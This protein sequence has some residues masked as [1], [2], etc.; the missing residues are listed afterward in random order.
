MPFTPPTTIGRHSGVF[1]FQRAMLFAG[2]PP[3]LPKLPPTYSNESLT[4]SASTSPSR[5]LDAPE[6]STP[7]VLDVLFHR[8]MLLAGVPPAVENQPPTNTL[9]PLTVIAP[10]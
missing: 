8:A 9:P 1:R 3:A 10:T 2:R 5:P 6:P 4:P 7:H